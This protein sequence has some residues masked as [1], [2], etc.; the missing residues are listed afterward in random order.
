M[1]RRKAWSAVKVRLAALSRDQRGITGL[2]T[3][4]ILIA[5]VVVASVFAFTVLSTGLFSAERS[6]ETVHAGL[7]EARGS[8]EIR[9]SVV[10]HDDAGD[11][12]SDS[13]TSTE[14]ETVVF[15]VTNAVAGE[16]IDLTAPT[17]GGNDGIPDSG[18]SHKAIVAYNDKNQSIPDVTWS[19]TFLGDNDG[20]N[21]LEV[22]ERAELTIQVARAI[23]T[24][25]NTNLVTDQEFTLEVKPPK[26]AV[27]IVQ[28]TTPSAIDPVMDLK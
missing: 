4:I 25:G 21:L 24:S 22:G 9:G 15:V 11:L 27:L 2:E 6:K 3:A 14:V 23:N 10:A 5:F 19:R 8:M 1:Q 17:D 7:Q 13:V 28:R 18:S 16:P 26:G 20:D 12:D